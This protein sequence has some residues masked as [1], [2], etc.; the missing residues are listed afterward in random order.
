MAEH[1]AGHE[2]EEIKET[3]WKYM[4]WTVVLLVCIG[5]GVFI[6]WTV[7]GDAAVLRRDLN[8]ATEQVNALKNDRENVSSKLALMT[9][10]YE[11]CQEKLKAQ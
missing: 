5:A 7:W 10:E 2:A 6:G 11:T 9:R 3:I 8:A 1:G 4:Q